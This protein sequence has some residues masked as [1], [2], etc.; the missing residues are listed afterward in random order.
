MQESDGNQPTAETPRN[1]ILIVDDVELN[2]DVLSIMFSQNHEVLF[3]ESGPE[4]IEII[5]KQS[6]S[7]CAILL[8]YLM[9]GMDGL[10]FLKTV[11]GRG[12]ID[13]IP[14]FLITASLEHDVVHLAYDLGVMDYIQRPISPFIV[15]RRIE[16][17]IELYRTRIQYAR[18]LKSQKHLLERLQ[19]A[20]DP[21]PDI[22]F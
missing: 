12:L 11:R 1:T 19:A 22:M 7:I 18:L 9:P 17:V 14:V 3:A 13:D 21:A 6:N 5:Q 20:E 15:Q 4:A 8:D 2:R 16:N 10:T